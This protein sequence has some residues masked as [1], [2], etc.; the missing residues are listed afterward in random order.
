MDSSPSP[1]SCSARA[2]TRMYH[3]MLRRLLMAPPRPA[4]KAEKR[5][6][7]SICVPASA[8]VRPLGS[9][10]RWGRKTMV[11]MKGKPARKA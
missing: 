10:K 2:V 11:T 7:A 8:G 3:A 9:W 6:S 1:R 5:S 4:P